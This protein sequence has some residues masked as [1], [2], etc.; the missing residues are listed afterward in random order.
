MYF[1]I[2]KPLIPFLILFQANTILIDKI[3]AV[4]DKEIITMTDIDKA[5]QFYPLFRTGG[6]S[7]ESFFLHV[8]EELITYKAVYLEYRD[9]FNLL[10]QDYDEVQ[11]PIIGKL[12]SL[13]KLMA[14]LKRFDME[15]QDFKNFIKEKVMYEKVLKEKFQIRVDIDFQE[16]ETFYNKEYLPL[17]KSL[18][19]QPKTL[20]EMAPFIEKHLGKIRINQKLSEWIKEIR[21]SYKIENILLEESK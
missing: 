4:V 6:E 15:W 5:I 3:A 17:Q 18:D 13:D 12:G 19:L 21:S 8:L 2:L 14:L 7:E 9:D 1:K 10:E 20:I 16:I 11:T